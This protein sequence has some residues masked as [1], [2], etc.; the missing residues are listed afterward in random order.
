MKKLKGLKWKHLLG[1]A[2]N[3][4]HP[5]HCL[6]E[7]WATLRSLNDLDRLREGPEKRMSRR[8]TG[9]GIVKKMWSSTWKCVKFV[10]FVLVKIQKIQS[11]QS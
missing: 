9:R 7:R 4:G 5:R 8:E 6:A 3:L 11:V 1:C 10:L 2:A